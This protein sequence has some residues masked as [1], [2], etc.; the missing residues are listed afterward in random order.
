MYSAWNT[1]HIKISKYNYVEIS[2]RFQN[3]IS[4]LTV[5]LAVEMKIHKINFHKIQ[6]LG[7]IIWTII[8]NRCRDMASLPADVIEFK[9]SLS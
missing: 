7:T 3:Y 8:D 4:V 9:C 1:F 5:E 2:I 6:F